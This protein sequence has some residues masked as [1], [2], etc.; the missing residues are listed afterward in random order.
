M[1]LLL[2]MQRVVS[3][4]DSLHVR[5]DDLLIPA[6]HS[7]RHQRLLLQSYRYWVLQL[8]LHYQ[9]PDLL[10][11]WSKLHL[12]SSMRFHL[13]RSNLLLIHLKVH[14]MKW[15][16]N[17]IKVLLTLQIEFLE[18]LL[19]SLNM[20]KLHIQMPGRSS[21]LW[22]RLLRF[23]SHRISFLPIQIQPDHPWFLL[24]GLPDRR[25]WYFDIV[26]SKVQ[27]QGLKLQHLNSLHSC[28]LWFPVLC[29]HPSQYDR[30]L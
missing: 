17:Y 16:H 7:Q 6:V 12:V 27:R 10:P 15:Y 28:I 4:S 3:R 5:V 2:Q 29:M 22:F 11:C 24:L 20:R 21:Q 9:Q 13:Y 1:L 25:K 30:S 14:A 18:D 8:M 26:R 23:R 19:L